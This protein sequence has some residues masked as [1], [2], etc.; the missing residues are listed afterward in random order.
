MRRPGHRAPPG[1]TAPG[2]FYEKKPGS[3]L[4]YFS[5]FFTL[6]LRVVDLSEEGSEEEEKPG[7]MISD[8][9]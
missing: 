1:T 5:A 6:L 9:P 3:P 7:K 2:A 4:V 8:N